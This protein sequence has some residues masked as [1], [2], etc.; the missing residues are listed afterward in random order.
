MK[1]EDKGP[2]YLDN[3]VLSSRESAPRPLIKCLSSTHL[4][5]FNFDLFQ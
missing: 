4:S 5:C 3:A 1:E 2:Y